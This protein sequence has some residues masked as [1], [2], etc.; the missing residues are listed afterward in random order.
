MNDRRIPSKEQPQNRYYLT[1]P[2]RNIDMEQDLYD[3]VF[4]PNKDNMNSVALHYLGIT[5]TFEQLQTT[6]D[7]IANALYAAG[8]R[9]NDVILIGVS[10]CPDIV[11]LLLGINKIGAVSKWFD[12][13][14]G[15]NDIRDYAN[16]SSC[17][18]LII[19]DMLLPRVS[20]VIENTCIEKVLIITPADSLSGLKR[21]L[22]RYNHLRKR[23]PKQVSGATFAYLTD[24]IN[25]VFVEAK[26]AE[27]KKDRPAVI[28]QSSGTTGKPKNI[29]HTCY[30][31]AS[32]VVKCTY[33]DL[34]VK[35]GKTAIDALPPWI[36]YALGAAILY[37][38]CMGC[39]VIL[40]PTFEPDTLLPYLG[41]FNI[42][43]AAPF[44]YRYIAEQN[45]K[46]HRRLN[47]DEVLVSGGDKISAEENE[48]LEKIL[49]AKLVNGY[50]NNE[51]WGPLTVNTEHDNHYGTVG[52]PR[53]GDVLISYD[54]DSQCELPFNE[55]GE[56][57]VLTE[58]RFDGYQGTEE[59]N[60]DVLKI[61]RDGRMWLHTGDLGFIDP[62]GFVTL[63]GRMRRVIIRRGFKIS[64]YT[65]EDKI[66]AFPHVKEC[67][68]VS[69]EDIAEEHVPMAFIVLDDCTIDK[70]VFK[71]D[72]LNMLKADLKA[73]EVPKYIEIVD[74]LPYTTN[75]K[76]DFRLLEEK[77]N[78]Y[79]QRCGK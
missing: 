36:A 2:A 21:T 65:I 63:C 23:F 39:S 14:A 7:R 11:A 45:G 8:I 64:A 29:L 25:G 53:Y 42:A 69:V 75:K 57:C 73:Y 66:S 49:N 44:H 37:P 16:G 38:L 32:G 9:E 74:S 12:V 3:L 28:V 46:L 40:C 48:R 20:K 58:A 68:A 17:R 5:W 59:L 22:Y 4:N 77:G 62:D 70:E 24:F 55:I 47:G 18:F 41:K 10:N 27:Y 54:N 1:R 30:S 50:G 76:Y 79:V 19:F 52:I 26:H 72:L 13:R 61:H 78:A 31:V 60:A 15:E 56:L 33:Y 71:K 51:A 34:P 6:T 67:I 43:M 35:L